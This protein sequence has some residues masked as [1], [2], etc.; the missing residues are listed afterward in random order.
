METTIKLFGN[1]IK[2]IRKK[3]KLTQE[4]LSEKVGLDV[5]TISRIE[6]GYYFTSYENLEKL[7][8][9][10]NVD[11]K[12]LFNFQN[13]DDKDVLREKIENKLHQL[14]VKDLQ[15]VLMFIQECL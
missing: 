5:Q 4:Q 8:I 15:K 6:T 9:A 11:I 10:L 1:R 14:D 13:I 12:D 7:A 2:E 3:L